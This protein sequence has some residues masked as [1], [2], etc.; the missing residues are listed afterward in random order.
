MKVITINESTGICST[1][2][3]AEH[4]STRKSF[5]GKILHCEEFD[6][7][8]PQT[9]P[10]KKKTNKKELPVQY[11]PVKGLCQNCD[12][13]GTCVLPKPEGGVW[14]CNEYQ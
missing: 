9:L 13:L 12:Q 3:H 11:A 1:C 14:F 10:D 6:D 2:I 5:K 8:I 7:Y 4:C